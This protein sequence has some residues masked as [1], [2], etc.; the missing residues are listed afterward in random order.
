[1][2]RLAASPKGNGD[3]LLAGRDGVYM[4]AESGPLQRI[5]EG[6]HIDAQFLDDRT[7]VATTADGRVFRLNSAPSRKRP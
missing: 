6:V 4:L 1:M 5:A 7:I 2:Q 3:L